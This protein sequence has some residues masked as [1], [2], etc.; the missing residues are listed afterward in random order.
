[1]HRAAMQDPK[2][3]EII[4]QNPQAQAIMS[5]GMAHLME[6]VAF[7]YRV[8]LQKQAG[9]ALPPPPDYDDDSGYLTP[10]QETQ[11]SR[12]VVAASSQLLQKD[13]AE[14]QAKQ[15]AQKQQ[16]PMVQMQQ[17]ELQIKQQEVQIKQQALQMEQQ[18]STAEQQR[19][20]A[21]D[22]I[23]KEIRMAELQLKQQELQLTAQLDSVKLGA[24]IEHKKRQVMVDAAHKTDTHDLKEKDL[25]V[26]AA[27]HEDNHEH[28]KSKHRHELIKTMAGEKHKHTD[29]MVNAARD[30]DR[31]NLEESKHNLETVKTG[32]DIAH[33]HYRRQLDKHK[34]D[35]TLEAQA[36]QS[37]P[38][39]LSGE[40]GE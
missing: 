15:N 19:K 38:Q 1:V 32:V 16:D 36:Q 28:E 22:Q 23:N 6:H 40:E 7:Q 11:M 18:I 3:M 8:E 37:E 20:Q 10:L 4:G 39:D 24:D 5:A 27:T 31:Q 2:L 12:A 21:Q 35:S 34:H 14:A 13:Q 17:Q 25:L 30:A 33:E 9:F 29:R 26:R